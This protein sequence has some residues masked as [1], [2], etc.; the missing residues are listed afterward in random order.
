[1]IFPRQVDGTGRLQIWSVWFQIQSYFLHTNSPD[2]TRFE[3]KEMARKVLTSMLPSSDLFER[4][5]TLSPPQNSRW[6][7]KDWVKENTYHMENRWI[8]N[9]SCLF[10]SSKSGQSASEFDYKKK[11]E[12]EWK[13]EKGFNVN[14]F[15]SFQFSHSVVS[16]PLWPHGL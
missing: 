8:T 10:V 16:D 6:R 12:K 11:K 9:S 15:S 14:Q 1:M 2:C 13:S 7:P 3:E 5:L 4:K